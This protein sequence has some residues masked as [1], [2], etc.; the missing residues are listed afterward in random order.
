[1]GMPGSL[2]GK[3]VTSFD[4]PPLAED[5]ASQRPPRRHPTH[6]G[7]SVCRGT[8]QPIYLGRM[9]GLILS[10][11]AGAAVTV[12]AKPPQQ[13]AEDQ[14][15]TMGRLA[16]RLAATPSAGLPIASALH[17][18]GATAGTGDDGPGAVGEFAGGQAETA[19]AVDETGQHI[20]IGFN[21]GRGFDLNPISGSGF[22]YS[23]DGGVT[24]V[25]GG[26]LPS[27][28]T[29]FIGTTAYPQL[30]G[31]PDV[32]YLGHG[33][34]IYSSIMNKKFGASAV[35]Q[36]VCV[37]R[38][39][40][41][42]HTWSGPFEVPSATNPHGVLDGGG[43]PQDAADKELIDVDP[44]TGR[45][46]VAWSNFTP[47]APGG[48]EIST[49]F[50]DDAATGN[51]PTWSVR[52][53]VSDGLTYSQGAV[54]RFAG[55]GSPDVYASWMRAGA[56]LGAAIVFAKSTDNGVSW[57]VPFD[58]SPEFVVMDEVLG[59]DR[60]SN[61]SS[62]AVDLSPGAHSGNV[63]VVY[64]D[65]DIGDGADIVFQRS[66]NHGATFSTRVALNSRPGVDR[67]QWFPF[68]TVDK[69]TGRVWVFYY[70]QGID[71]SGD[72]TEVTALHSDDGGTTWSNPFA[73][74]PRPFHAGHGND[75]SQPNLGDYNQGT[76][77]SGGLLA[78]WA[79]THQI[80]FTD[81][82]P[83]SRAFT[84]PDVQVTPV[85][86]RPMFASLSLGDPHF[87]ETGGD[88][89]IDSDDL[90]ELTIPLRNFV[91]NPISEGAVTGI[92]ATLSTTC[93]E[94]TILDGVSSYPTATVSAS[95]DNNSSFVLHL[96]PA[97]IPGTPL[98]LTLDLVS[99]QGTAS[100]PF[101]LPTGTPI[102]TP[103]LT[104]NFNG[105][106]P[107]SLPSG[108]SA[109]NG[110]HQGFA[111]V[112]WTTN[113]T[114]CGT[115]S[116]A[117]FHQNANDGLIGLPTR[118]ERLFSPTVTVPADADYVLL[119]FDVCYDTED[120][121]NFNVRAYDGFF[122]RINDRLTPTSSR[123]VLAEAFEEEFTTGAVKHYPRHLPRSQNPSYFEDMSV[124]AG[125]SGGPQ[126]VRMRLPG[127][128]GR[129]VQLR[130]EYT[131]DESFTCASVRPGHTC[132]VQVDNIVMN[133]VTLTVPS[134]FD[135]DR[136]VDLA[137][138]S[139]FWT[140]LQGPSIPRAQGCTREDLDNNNHVDL[141]DLARWQRAF[142]GP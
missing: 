80:A 4:S 85:P 115:S 106:G 98:E 67:A 114:F 122:L 78:A 47:A 60:V 69:T 49:T 8:I 11:W 66:V 37:H 1:M 112:P 95:V 82:L 17:A 137:D 46:M 139:A 6:G 88:G 74:S 64:S 14:M 2:R 118:W 134:D 23:D 70:D 91:T 13:S 105:V 89:V 110:A 126:H 62:L 59:N 101:T 140:C 54:P 96:D 97:F 42:G 48:V 30:F 93:P 127:M 142:T 92:V 129:T 31:D 103:I 53:V 100:L 90:V 138:Y 133:G 72:R 68:V 56:G 77:Q 26:Q 136:D 35:A 21:D 79:G 41:F 71:A 61:F 25:D 24:W 76:A 38:S 141:L 18:R 132:G 58:L 51:P 63:Y 128:A 75:T 40:D 28:G 99:D 83:T 5:D 44:D 104:E 108:W 43:N 81:G 73:I 15:S 34:F 32:K 29:D 109:V 52:R 119:E 94:A 65:N 125:D 121:P 124:W 33:T 19:I 7:D 116:N 131:Q 57:G 87:V 123:S 117:A 113:N 120:D 20:V 84:V 111:V 27:P 135:R 107:G 86:E 55:N 39:I 50:S 16:H 9:L 45:V 12:Q 22:A 102:A 10:A 36:T 130:F 3:A